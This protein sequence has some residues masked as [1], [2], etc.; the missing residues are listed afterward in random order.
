[1]QVTT[2]CPHCKAEVGV[3]IQDEKPRRK[4]SEFAWI[5][6]IFFTTLLTASIGSY[7]A[8][9]IYAARVAERIKI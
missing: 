3:Q 9:S 5:A 2:V 1:M 4:T 8:V 7:F 6:A